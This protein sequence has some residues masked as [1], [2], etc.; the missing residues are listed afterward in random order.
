MTD[1]SALTFPL[2]PRSLGVL[3]HAWASGDPDGAAS[4]AHECLCE[5]PICKECVPHTNVWENIFFKIVVKN[6]HDVLHP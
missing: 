4:R 3:V 6:D 2:P 5:T 1:L